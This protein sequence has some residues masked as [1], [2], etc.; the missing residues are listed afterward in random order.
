[1]YSKKDD[2]AICKLLFE[3]LNMTG[4]LKLKETFMSGDFSA[5]FNAYREVTREPKKPPSLLLA[6]YRKLE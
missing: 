3:V 6:R 2:T 1:M 5:Y 4:K